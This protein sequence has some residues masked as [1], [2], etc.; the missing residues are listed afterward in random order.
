MIPHELA[1]LTG[2]DFRL[3]CKRMWP[4]V[5]ADPFVTGYLGLRFS[6]E[7]YLKD[8]SRTLIDKWL[9]EHGPVVAMHTRGN[10]STREKNFT[11]ELEAETYK[12]IVGAT[13]AT[14]LLLDWDRRVV[15]GPKPR[16]IHLGDWHRLNLVEVAYL[17]NRAACMVGIDSGQL[18]LTEKWTN[19]PALGVWFGHHPAHFSIPRPGVTHLVASSQRF[20]AWNRNRQASYSLQE[21][22]RIT[23]QTIA[24]LVRQKISQPGIVSKNHLC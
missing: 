1:K 13:D 7:Q 22:E 10:T 5:S 8:E 24:E 23:G 12:A 16:V 2:S 9:N 20:K 17:L 14:I 11:P 4:A 19:C 15:E 3:F 21:C 6:L 18:H